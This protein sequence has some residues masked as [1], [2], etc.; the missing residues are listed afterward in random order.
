MSKQDS[1]IP[2]DFHGSSPQL[3]IRIALLLSQLETAPFPAP[4]P[5][6]NVYFQQQRGDEEYAKKCNILML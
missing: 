3:S 5:A 1:Q 2:I 4:F 6:G